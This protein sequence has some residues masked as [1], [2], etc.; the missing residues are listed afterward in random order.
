MYGPEWKRRI[1]EAALNQQ[2]LCVKLSACNI[3][4]QAEV[5]LAVALRQH[6]FD[7]CHFKNSSCERYIFTFIL[8]A[9]YAF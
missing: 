7:I 8:F 1:T 3:N 6:R 4:W 5:F 2:C 9:I